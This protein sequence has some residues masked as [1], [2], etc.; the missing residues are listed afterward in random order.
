MGWIALQTALGTMNRPKQIT[1]VEVRDALLDLIQRKFY[2]ADPIAFTKDHK[3]LLEWVILWPAVWL[4][5]RGVSVANDD[6]RKIVS[7]IL[8]EAAAHGNTSKVNYRPAWL[9]FVVQS[10]FDHHGEEYYNKAKSVRSLADHQLLML[11]KIQPKVQDAVVPAFVEA[12]RLL[13]TKKRT[14]RHETTKQT[15]LF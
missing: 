9:R 8:I 5:Q 4:N 3:R 1:S 2:E 10:H 13:K 6:Y 12:S 11:G 7:D 14:V 15:T